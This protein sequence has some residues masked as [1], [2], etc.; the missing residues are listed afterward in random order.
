MLN[1]YVYTSLYAHEFD[2]ALASRH[3]Q[4][5]T[6]PLLRRRH[7]KGFWRPMPTMPQPPT[8]STDAL[9]QASRQ[10]SL[11][12]TGNKRRNNPAATFHFSSNQQTQS[13]QL[14]PFGR[15][16]TPNSAG[17]HSP[18][19]SPRRG[20]TIIQLVGPP[21][22]LPSGAGGGDGAARGGGANG[23]RMMEG[24]GGAGAAL[25]VFWDRPVRG[26]SDPGTANYVIDGL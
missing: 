11:S 10:S 16:F 13:T 25:E 15:T 24:D 14:N 18:P 26:V 4:S 2:L 7:K 1:V 20:H 9:P 17:L 21:A 3:H 19:G 8:E 12:F 5:C 23:D 22:S 6:F